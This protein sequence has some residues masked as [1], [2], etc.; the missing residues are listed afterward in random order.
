[1]NMLHSNVATLDAPTAFEVAIPRM[2]TIRET[3]KATGM[4]EYAVRKMVKQNEVV[5]VK[6]GTKY[7]INFDRFV[8]FLNGIT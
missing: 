3:A 6:A 4:S 8:D 7:L 2:T 5:F 1:M